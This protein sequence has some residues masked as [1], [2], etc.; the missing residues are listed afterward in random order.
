MLTDIETLQRLAKFVPYV[1]I[2]LGFLLA[3]SGQFVRSRIDDHLKTLEKQADINRKLTPP[4]VDADIALAQDSRKHVIVIK[5]KNRI[6]FRADWRINTIK[7]ELV[8]GLMLH[9]E[10]FLPDASR[11]EFIYN[12]KLQDDRI[13]EDYLELR[14]RSAYYLEMGSPENLR[15]V[16]TKRYKLIEGVPH[17]L[18]SP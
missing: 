18:K 15:G 7:D 9:E 5:C 13:R 2:V 16:L 10:E 6:P 17:L 8:S 12:V 14:W 1:F 3:I 4:E 11:D